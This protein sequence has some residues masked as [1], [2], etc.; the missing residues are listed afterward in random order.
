MKDNRD[1]LPEALR[2]L[3]GRIRLDFPMAVEQGHYVGFP[4]EFAADLARFEQLVRED[5]Q[6]RQKAAGQEA[7]A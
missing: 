5:E 6:T 4:D 7:A 2:Y 1:V 3:L